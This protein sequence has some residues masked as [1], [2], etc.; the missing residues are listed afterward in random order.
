M[1]DVVAVYFSHLNADNLT[2]SSACAL[3]LFEHIVCTDQEQMV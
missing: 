3:L 2:T 1:V